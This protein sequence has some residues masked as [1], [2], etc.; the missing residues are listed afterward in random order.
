MLSWYRAL[1][2]LVQVL[3]KDLEIALRKIEEVIVSLL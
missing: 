2:L 3:V 1:F